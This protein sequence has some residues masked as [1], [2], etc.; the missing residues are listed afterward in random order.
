[1]ILRR[2]GAAWILLVL[3]SM[4][5]CPIMTALWFAALAR[6]PLTDDLTRAAFQLLDGWRTR[7]RC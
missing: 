3:A 7:D 5:T 2:F 1:V 4:T 6:Q